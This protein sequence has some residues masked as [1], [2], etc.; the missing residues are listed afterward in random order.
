MKK[1]IFILI[2]V[3]L[4]IISGKMISQDNKFLITADGRFDDVR[5]RFG[6]TFKL[7]GLTPKSIKP[8]GGTNTVNAVPTQSCSSGYFALFFAPGSFFDNNSIAQNA[9][10]QV[11]T[12]VSRFIVSPLSSTLSAVKINIYCDNTPTNS[13]ATLGTAS[14]LFVFPS[15]PYNANQG[16][17]DNQIYK[18]ITSG[19]NPFANIPMGPFTNSNDFYYGYVNCN[20]SANWNFNINS[21]SSGS[22]T[23]D[24]YTIFLHEIFHSLGF[25]SL[26]DVTGN[27][28][29]GS[30]NNY[31]GR[32]DK[33]LYNHNGSA[34]LGSSTPSCS[35]S[36]LT[37]T[38]NLSSIGN[39]T[40][41]CNTGITICTTAIQYIGSTTS[42]IYT[43]HCFE[44]GSSLSHF[45]DIC[46]APTFTTACT[47]SSANWNDLYF[48]MSQ[49][50]GS[51]SCFIKRYP[52]EEE[53]K[54][55]C[56]L[57]YSVN[58]TYSCNASG[59]IIDGSLNYHTYTASACSGPNLW[60][61]NDGIV[62]SSYIYT[63]S[64]T[65]TNA[66]S[67]STAAI[68]GNDSPN[69]VSMSCLEVIYNNAT[70]NLSGSNLIV[71][72]NTGSTGL[73]IIKYLPKDAG[74]NFGTPVYI[75][76]YFLSPVCNPIDPC[77]MIQN[78]GF[79]NIAG[80]SP[81][82]CGGLFGPN[83]PYFNNIL[84][85]CWANYA[86]TPDY[87]VR[88]C[89]TSN[90][91]SSPLVH[92]LGTNTYSLSPPI[93]SYNSPNNAVMAIAAF[94][95]A[96]S[97]VFNSEGMMTTLGSSLIPGQ[98]YQISLWANNPGAPSS[99]PYYTNSSTPVVLSIASMA[100][101]IAGT[102][103]TALTDFTINP[104]G[105]WSQFTHTFVF[106]PTVSQSVLLVYIETAKTG[107][108]NPTLGTTIVYVAFDDLSLKPLPTNTFVIPNSGICGNTSFTNLAQYASP[109]PGVFTGTGVTSITTGTLTQYNFNSSGTLTPGT[110]PVAFT[111]TNFAGCV[112]NLWQNI[113][114]TP[115]AG[116]TATLSNYICSNNLTS[117]ISASCTS[118]SGS[119]LYAW[120]PGNLFGPSV[121]VSP[122]VNTVYTVTAIGG[123]CT[124][125][126]TLNLITNCCAPLSTPDF[127][128]TSVTSN[129]ILSGPLRITSDFTI[130]TGTCAFQGGEFI[131]TN[132]AK[133]TVASGAILD[134]RGA[135][136]YTCGSAMWKGIVVKSGGIVYTSNYNGND[137]LI[138]DAETAI[139]VSNYAINTTTTILNIA[140]TTFNKNYIDI[141]FFNYPFTSSSYANA[142]KLSQCVFTCRNFTFSPSAWPQASISDLRSASGGTAILSAPYLMQGATVAT[143]KSPHNG[144]S[145]RS[146]LS[147]SNVGSTSSGNYYTLNMAPV[148]G[149]TPT[150]DFLLF[151]AHENFITA[152]NSNIKI[153]NSVFQSTQSYSANLVRPAIDYSCNISDMKLDLSAT[154][155]AVGNRFYNCHR[156]VNVTNASVFKAE[157]ALFRSSQSTAAPSTSVYASPGQNAI[158]IITNP[159]DDY[160][161]QN[162]EFT[163]I[164]D[165]IL[166]GF[167][168]NN[169]LNS[170][171]IKNNTF[172]PY[173][174]TTF[175][176]TSTNYIKSAI[177]LVDPLAQTHTSALP[178]NTLGIVIQNNL[179]YRV[180]N[181]LL[182][183]GI[184]PHYSHYVTRRLVSTNTI[185]LEEDPSGNQQTGIDN[186]NCVNW[187]YSDGNSTQSIEQ[188]SITLYGGNTS[189]TNI[190]L[191]HA[192]NN[193]GLPATDYI[194]CN[195]LTA[196]YQGF[197]FEG[198]NLFTYWRGNSMSNL[199]RG[200]S[201]TNAG[202]IQ[203]Q[204][205]S[206]AP[207]DNK[208]LGTTWTGTNSGTYVDATSAATTSIL[209]VK[210]SSTLTP[211]NNSGA[212]LTPNLYS[213]AGNVQ[214]TTG[215]YTCG[216]G[217][218][219]RP[220][221]L[222]DEGSYTSADLLYI[223]KAQIFQVLYYNDSIRGSTTDL[224]S[225]YDALAGS[226]INKFMQVEDALQAQDLSAA[227]AILSGLATGGFNTVEDNYLDFYNLYIDYAGATGGA[228]FTPDNLSALAA[229]ASLCPGTNGAPVYKAR[230]LY[231]VITG[232][233]FNGAD[234]CRS[235]ARAAEQE[236]QATGS[237]KTW[238]I[239]LYP[240][241]NFGNFV[242]A[243]KVEKEV[244]EISV[245]DVSG[246]NLYKKQVRTEQYKCT[247][248]LSLANGI[249]F[250]TIKNQAN[251]R[252]TKK[253]VVEK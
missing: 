60:G 119:T 15:N 108:L 80:N 136:F 12:D 19:I 153:V 213:G 216:A 188:N 127:T 129:T 238:D 240:N 131:F 212:A 199:A 85:N 229:L 154:S 68:I 179:L 105:V 146:A 218:N 33:F 58:A 70:V 18:A 139:D 112:D 230:A 84:I 248:D 30:A 75:F 67:I 7:S 69:T 141:N 47:G 247:F 116:L 89:T 36:N 96:V 16:I 201:L 171:A 169:Y 209:Y 65:F 79:E 165:A 101:Y 44:V 172:S 26:I 93:N 161:I 132:N 181:G 221:G 145:S 95:N 175:T 25:M 90:A 166:I 98:A 231:Q 59:A 91:T 11:F 130:Q 147:F 196:A 97:P 122:T 111:Y 20:P 63:A 120:Q 220:G 193:Y 66:I 203:Q 49:A 110:Y 51:G 249:Y 210:S 83:Y 222:P 64:V 227:Q 113:S 208:W 192:F 204:G 159:M 200:M 167:S 176:G 197:V 183:D 202:I 92:N 56:D 107:S 190:S 82:Q 250:V 57:G 187:T 54:V 125:S 234:G 31:F 4:V 232:T 144:L 109:I 191:L 106:T 177:S 115:S 168:A 35:N 158:N 228:P 180:Y 2:Q 241:P 219:Q 124:A 117:T 206:G 163:N 198:P 157:Y 1:C 78:G 48:V 170:L 246:R 156:A 40:S 55:L 164:K 155:S 148:S 237:K 223:A 39:A 252:V 150:A 86:G 143:L 142:I 43:P 224:Q 13:P 194:I 17:I 61:V 9:L 71:T 174:S 195:T 88:G 24:F 235:G 207:S 50:Q 41:S 37:F 29:F 134:I 114:V 189:N 28:Y 149:G 21:G 137:C 73:V 32:Y 186:A 233:A 94:V 53:R 211:P 126:Q 133:I 8:F 128:L 22:T 215:T 242:I 184:T 46:T 173:L 245:S 74:G 205:K 121:S 104:G 151:D 77:V 236:V 76:T 118:C 162:N 34:L 99:F 251:E 178:N 243:G 102:P 5:D 14:P 45:E 225:F 135:H 27:S 253:M 72:I 244:L 42:S 140:N 3:F 226:S 103:Y 81:S 62:N 23:Y 239:N 214:F 152:I 185:T 6:N 100:Q 87:F 10:C 182:M 38:T 138:E 123:S 217:Y 52:K 160:S